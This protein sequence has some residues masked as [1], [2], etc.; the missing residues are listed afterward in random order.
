[1][2]KI[3]SASQIRQADAYTIKHEPITSWALM[4]RASQAFVDEFCTHVSME[5]TI[6]VVAGMG[7]NGGDGL[8]IARLLRNKGYQVKPVLLQW[9]GKLSEDCE[10]TLTKLSDVVQVVSPE[11]FSAPKTDVLIDAIFGSGL[12]RP[13][14]GGLAKVIEQ[15]NRSSAMRISV[16]I[17]SGLFADEVNGEGEIVRADMTITFQCPKLSML[18]PE[19][20]I[21]AGELKIVDIGLHRAFVE[22]LGGH[23]HYITKAVE[24]LFPQRYKFQ[25]KGNFGHVQVFA[26]S[27]GKIGAAYL[28][29]KGAMR[30][31]AGLLTLHV[32]QC[33]MAIL[34][35]SL[36][37]A[38]LTLDDDYAH[39]SSSGILDKTNVVCFGPGVGTHIATVEAL[40]GLLE[41]YS[42]PL[43]IDADGLNILS[44]HSELADML[45]VNTI[46]TPH[47]GEFHRLFGEHSHGLGRIET[48]RQQAMRREWI[49]VLKGAH[50][51]IVAPNGNVYFNSTGNPGMATAGSG[52]VLAGVISGLLAQGLSPLEAAQ[53]AVY[54][55]GKAGDEAAKNVGKLSLMASDL[56][57]FLP[58]SNLNV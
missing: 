24:K 31:G 40:R 44:E 1:M 45:P 34:Q 37:E 49:I 4:E 19:S 9:Q 2:L 16:D 46:I 48:A 22:Q 32:P 50:T 11:D 53:L 15:L 14:T 42:G 57:E 12:N 30:A 55:H 5:Q 52:D 39:I 8:A 3:L 47:V 26:G 36:P 56:L 17:P 13:V 43:V 25:H 35:T 58:T 6:T 20:G 18:L 29:A 28:C 51:A 23:Y 27:L 38:M 33:A 10:K 54:W 41:S 7:N 21:Y